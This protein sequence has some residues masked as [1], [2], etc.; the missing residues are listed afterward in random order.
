[1]AVARSGFI[2][3]LFGQN[4]LEYIA[5]LGDMREINFGR[6]ALLGTRRLR[7]RLARGARSALE[8]RAHLVGLI[9]LQRTGVGL[10]GSQAEL[11]QY[12]ENLTAL[13][14]HLAR[15]IVNSNLT[16]PPLFKW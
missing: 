10:A 5:R 1:M 9:V 6:Y 13:D 4:S 3:L 2:F 16:H 11:C 15:K 14:L 8:M 12:V 7:A